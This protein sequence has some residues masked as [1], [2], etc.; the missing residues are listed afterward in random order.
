M[1]KKINWKTFWYTNLFSIITLSA[2]IVFTAKPD[3]IT[4]TCRLIGIVCCIAGGILLLLCLFPKLRSSQN[5]FYGSVFLV[6]GLLLLIVPVLL[7]FLIPILFG[8]WILSSS[9]SGMYRNFLFRHDVKRWWIGFALCAVSAL[10]AVFVMTRPTEVMDDTVRIIG[11]GFILHAVVRL[12][13]SLLG[14]DGYKAA[15]ENYVSTT[16]QE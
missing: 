10:L 3:I 9:L 4:A 1:F 16:I 7:K 13:S 5:I 12:V 6:I 8:A 2:G 11:I 14:M 15:N